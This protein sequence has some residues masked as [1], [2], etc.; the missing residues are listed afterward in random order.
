MGYQLD[1]GA[2]LS[3]A[4]LTFFLEGLQNTLTLFV[5]SWAAAFAFAVVLMLIRAT[6]I[7]PLEWF[8]SIYVEYH[9]NV[10]LLVQ[11]LVWYFGISSLFP[12]SLNE[13][14]N[15]NNA[16]IIFAMVALSLYAAAY[17][18]EDL[19]SGLRAIPKTQMEAG[20]AIGFT[21][22]QTMRWVIIPQTWRLA[23]PPL[24]NQ[25]LLIFKGTSL[26]A[27]I[28]VGELT[29]QA[30]QVESQSFRVFEAF[31]IVTLLYVLGSFILMF[32][33]SMLAR[34]YRLRTK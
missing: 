7:R 34:R 30:R 11:L 29:Y 10:P 28:G 32:A 17:M 18:S 27:A 19:R 2:V 15:D 20:R 25:T 14:M 31:S 4:Y 16:E 22:V 21:Y 3:G 13:F 26:A 1:Y 6:Q 9:R 8:V 23:L 12:R 33:G 24:I 5:A